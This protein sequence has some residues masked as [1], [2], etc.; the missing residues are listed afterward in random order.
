MLPRRPRGPRLGPSRRDWLR[1]IGRAT[2]A[3][4]LTSHACGDNLP[5]LAASDAVGAI[6]EPHSSG[7]T[8]SLWCAR[9][10]SVFV[11]VLHA[12]TGE[13]VVSRIGFLAANVGSHLTFTELPAATPFLVHATLHNGA[14][15]GPFFAR[16]A[17]PPDVAA[18]TRW[19]VAADIDI[20]SPHDPSIFANMVAADVDGAFTLG[21]F[22]YCDNG[23][24]LA[25]SLNEYRAIH[26]RTRAYPP[27]HRWLRSMPLRSIYDDH[28]FRNDWRPEFVQREGDRYAAAMAAWD[29][30][31]PIAGAPPEIRYRHWR[32][33]ALLE[34][35]VLDTRRFRNNPSD[36]ESPDKTI[37]G[38]PQLAWLL[39]GLAQSTAKFKIVSTSV[40]LG[41][42]NGIDHWAGYTT[43][44]AELMNALARMK[45]EGVL[46]IS[47]DQHWFASHRHPNGTR[48]A[49]FGAVARG[50]RLPPPAVDGVIARVE[51]LNFGVIDIQP[52]LITITDH[53]PDGHELYRE[54]LTAEAMRAS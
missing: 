3:A 19:V 29:E 54:A 48:E 18:P 46:F 8:L 23:P 37:L 11:E 25:W 10:T 28:E 51:G 1:F 47:G 7:F 53:H 43:E 14:E 30:F 36:P 5:Y 4:T 40:P 31:F 13:P 20:D 42:G 16:T 21:D 24:A 9:R 26:A 2:V 39:N 52:N 49:Q 35:F 50:P 6:V 12:V 44:R 33:G 41:F 45:K 27:I 15:I 17:P 22:P 32:W 38:K 34:G